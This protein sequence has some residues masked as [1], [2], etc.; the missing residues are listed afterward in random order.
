MGVH[1]SI[2]KKILHTPISSNWVTETN[3]S[4]KYISCYWYLLRIRNHYFKLTSVAQ[5][6]GSSNLNPKHEVVT[7]GVQS[8]Q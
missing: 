3:I 7:N 4:P 5:L 1:F 6:T 8:I 2:N